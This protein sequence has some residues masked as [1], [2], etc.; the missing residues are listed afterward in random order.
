M[1]YFRLELTTKIKKNLI[2][3]YSIYTHNKKK[4]LSFVEPILIKHKKLNT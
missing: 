2:V 3:I 4:S 1:G